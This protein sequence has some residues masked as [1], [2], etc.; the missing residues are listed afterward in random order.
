MIERKTAQGKILDIES[1]ITLNED[2]IAVGNAK[3]NAKGDQ[4]GP[5]G[6]VVSTRQQSANAYYKNNP[7]ASKI[8]QSIKDGIK[9]NN[10]KDLDNDMVGYAISTTKTNQNKLKN[11]NVKKN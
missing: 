7:K 9:N 11:K 3:M 5:G 4:V 8:Q 6:K 10:V 1:L 2:A